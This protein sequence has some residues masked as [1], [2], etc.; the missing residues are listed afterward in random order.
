MRLISK[1]RRVPSHETTKAWR[2]FIR[3]ANDDAFDPIYVDPQGNKVDIIHFTP[4]GYI[5]SFPWVTWKYGGESYVL[6]VLEKEGDVGEVILERVPESA[7][8]LLKAFGFLPDLDQR[9]F[10]VEWDTKDSSTGVVHD[11]KKL[12]L[13][14]IVGVPEREYHGNDQVADRLAD[15]YGWL[16]YNIEEI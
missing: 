6:L 2:N 8:H 16:V 10:R 7:Y 1:T 11:P 12:G 9:Y 3:W 14:E 13:P 15:K 4:S 5:M